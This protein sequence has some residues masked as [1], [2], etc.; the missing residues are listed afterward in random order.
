MI[1]QTFRVLTLCLVLA[2]AGD[3]SAQITLPGVPGARTVSAAEAHVALTQ[4]AIALDLRR[5]DAFQKARLPQARAAW[6]AYDRAGRRFDASAFAI[7][8]NAPIIFYHDGPDGLMAY[9]AV[10]AAV[11]AGHSNVMWLRGGLAEWA[12]NGLPTETGPGP[13]RAASARQALND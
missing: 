13:A 8:H 4:G 7:E 6:L 3:A 5:L 2:C 9:R 12:G 11:A 1:L 10:S